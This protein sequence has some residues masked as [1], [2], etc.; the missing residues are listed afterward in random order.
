[1]EVWL[2][3]TSA[4]AA[5]CGF[6]PVAGC[7]AGDKAM[8]AGVC[9]CGRRGRCESLVYPGRTFRSGLSKTASRKS[10]DEV[11]TVNLVNAKG[12]PRCVMDLTPEPKVAKRPD[13]LPKTPQMETPQNGKVPIPILAARS[14][15]AKTSL[16]QAELERKFNEELAWYKKRVD[17]LS[18][19]LD[20][21]RGKRK[22]LE[23]EL[24][25]IKTRTEAQLKEAREEAEDLK[26]RGGE[27]GPRAELEA[28]RREVES[29]RIE[30]ASLQARLADSSHASTAFTRQ[31]LE[32]KERAAAAERA[33]AAAEKSLAEL[34]AERASWTSQ[35]DAL[36]AQLKAQAQQ[37][38]EQA[39]AAAEAAA[40]EASQQAV[41]LSQL[42]AAVAEA[43]EQAA[44]AA[45]KA[46]AAE[47]QRQ[48]LSEEL[49]A[50]GRAVQ[51][52]QA[53][54]RSAQE[55][56]SAL[57]AQVAE[58][59]AAVAK[60]QA[61]VPQASRQDPC[62]H[63][64]DDWSVEDCV[65]GWLHVL[66]KADAVSLNEQLGTASAEVASLRAAGVSAATLN[67]LRGAL[68]RSQRE[69]TDL[70]TEY[71]RAVYEMAKAK[72]EHSEMAGRLNKAKLELSVS[73]Q[74]L[75]EARMTYAEVLM[76]AQLALDA[77]SQPTSLSAAA[78]PTKDAGA[79]AGDPLGSR[80]TAHGSNGGGSNGASSAG[81]G[82]G[83]AGGGGAARQQL[84]KVRKLAADAMAAALQDK[85]LSDSAVS[86]GSSALSAAAAAPGAPR[87]SERVSF[88]VELPAAGPGSR[89]GSQRNSGSGN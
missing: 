2:V 45:S 65:H 3:E 59:E 32:V 35:V 36:H 73:A 72:A 5:G 55:H 9:K 41:R 62:Q 47:Q 1:G 67:N 61:S 48:A 42:E 86:G 71:S 18:G 11:C 33:V 88:S 6:K 22:D 87:I 82:G 49:A 14:V 77:M 27:R 60:A 66:L 38:Q 64:A 37:A 58:L 4:A 76:A 84:E 80:A 52:A 78:S 89:P 12:D 24:E 28:A 31:Q 75:T 15:E 17:H 19:E 63:R 43:K 30:R 81:A 10:I 40:A 85:R 44:A 21:A 50:A 51:A 13:A 54:E 26:N 34:N 29:L 46:E 57:Q 53:G 79:G 68:S 8:P 83:G 25:D 74:R 69:L 39:Q 20:I 7:G 16:K 23:A 70:Q 56:S